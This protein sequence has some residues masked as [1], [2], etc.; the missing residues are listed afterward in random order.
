MVAIGRRRPG[1][2]SSVW[3]LKSFVMAFVPA[4]D[5]LLVVNNLLRS[6]TAGCALEHATLF[7]LSRDWLEQS[8]ACASTHQLS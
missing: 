5:P 4:E 8:P 7:C 3:V 1:L 2:H 6:A